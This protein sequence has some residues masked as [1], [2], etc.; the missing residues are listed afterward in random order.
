MHMHELLLHAV[1]QKASDLHISSGEV[2]M[3]R[4][5]GEVHR[6]NAPPLSPDETKRLIYSIMSERQKT[7]FEHDLE[8]DFSLGLK[9]LARFR[10]N[11]FN[12]TRGIGAAFRTIPFEIVPLKDL[13]LPSVVS[14]FARFRKGLVLVTGPTGSGKS[15]TLAGLIDL[16]NQSRADHILTIEDPVEF[17][18]RPKRSLIHQ[19][20]LGAHTRSFSN[21][22][23]SALREDPDVILIGE[24]RDLETVSL[25]LTAAET[26]HLVFATLHTRSSPDTIARIIDVFPPAQQEQ[27]RSMLSE[28]LRAVVSQNLLRVRDGRGR[29]CAV[30]ILINNFAVRNLIRENKVFQL[31]S[32]MQTSSQVGMVTMEQSLKELALKGRISREDAIEVSGNPNLFNQEQGPRN[33]MGR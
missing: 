28:S 8:L 7:Q 33:T 1:Q 23:R 22:L 5:H 4:V 29:V 31:Q 10:V 11:V 20:E 17:H 9:G 27:A 3:I 2:P 32:L 13:G 25:A 6:L 12:H 24:M 26:G 18:H 15:T 30:E 19:R 21:A 16:V 14:E